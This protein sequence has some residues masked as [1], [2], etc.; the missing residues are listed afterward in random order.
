MKEKERVEQ[1]QSAQPVPIS[2]IEA[3]TFHHHPLLIHLTNRMKH[4]EQSLKKE[5]TF[6][7]NNTVFHQNGS[8]WS[9]L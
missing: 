2:I 6:L 7:N 3:P 1:A 4:F 5:L 8:V 9:L